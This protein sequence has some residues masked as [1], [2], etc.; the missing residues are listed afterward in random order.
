MALYLLR[1]PTHGFRRSRNPL[2]IFQRAFERQFERLRMWFEGV[3]TMLVYRRAFFVPIFLLLCVSAFAL[4]PWLGQDFF[5]NTDNGQFLLH[6]RA[7]TGTRIEETARLCDL[8]ETYIRTRVPRSEVDN[9]LDNI[10]LPY[11]TINYTYN[12]SGLIG[13]GEADVLVSLKEKHSPTADYVR[14]L[15][16]ELPRQFP[17]ATFYFLPPD[18][19][20]QILNFGLPAPIDVQYDGP[21]SEGNK[22]VADRVLQQLRHVP[23][24]ADLRIQQQF[25]YPV[26]HVDVNRT[27]ASEAGFTPNNVASSLLVSLSGSFQTTPTFFLNWRNGVSYN[28]VT[29]TPQYEVQSLQDLQN[30]PI[31]APGAARP[32]ILADVASVNRGEDLAVLSHYNIHRVVDIYGDVQ[33][34][35]LGAVGRDITKIVDANRKN[36]PRGTFVKI[37]GQLDTMRESYIGLLIGLAFAIVLVY[38][39]IVVNFQSWLD[40][41]II[42]TALPAALGGIVLFLFITHTTL[43][44]P[45]L[46]GAIMCMGV[47][48]SNS[49]LVVSF[50]KERLVHHG[51]AIG[52]AIEA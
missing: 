51:D 39:L 35:D 6:V 22:V 15:R 1:P 49:I 23:G 9:I 44:V 31:T 47:A 45:A 20:T 46:M 28:L 25:D 29:Q 2:V 14:L 33:D 43:S 19:V 16:K 13:A 32:E 12:R 5:P 41:F 3:L 42:I 36:L 52:A 26:L 21:D 30:T 4:A 40:P 18:I 8:V 11:S 48:T 37:R 17:S 10:G 50:A 7:Q 38:L 27:K 24:I 34:R